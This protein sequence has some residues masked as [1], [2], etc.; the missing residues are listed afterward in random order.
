MLRNKHAC[1]KPLGLPPSRPQNIF[2]AIRK[3]DST[4]FKS[5]NPLH[6]STSFLF[7]GTR[8]TCSCS[9]ILFSPP[10]VTHLHVSVT[11][12]FACPSANV[13]VILPKERFPFH[14]PRTSRFYT[15]YPKPCKEF[16]CKISAL[17]CLQKKTVTHSSKAMSKGSCRIRLFFWIFRTKFNPKLSNSVSPC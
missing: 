16:V 9:P 14:P 7:N 15:F 13:P 4:N 3:D 10:I 2:P 17:K 11:V 12:T 8:T 1:I 5:I 6:S